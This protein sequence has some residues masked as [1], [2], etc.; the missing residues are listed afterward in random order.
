MEYSKKAVFVIKRIS[1][2]IE[3]IRVFIIIYLLSKYIKN[4][5]NEKYLALLG[6]NL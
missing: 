3:I 4:P 6:F 2:Y 1:V 5:S